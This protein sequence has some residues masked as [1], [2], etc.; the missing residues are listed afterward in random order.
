MTQAWL[1]GMPIQSQGRYRVVVNDF[2][3]TGGD[4]FS[5]FL[6]GTDRLGGPPDLEAFITAL[7]S[8]EPVAAPGPVRLQRLPD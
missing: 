6:D 7:S 4:G 5:G 2:L 3:A 1:Q 8:D